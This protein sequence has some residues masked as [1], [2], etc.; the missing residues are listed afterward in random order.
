[1]FFEV[2]LQKLVKILT[3]EIINHKLYKNINFWR[4]KLKTPQNKDFLKRN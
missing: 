2:I 1:M 3:F 4:Y